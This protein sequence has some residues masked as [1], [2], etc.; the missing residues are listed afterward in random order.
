[1]LAKQVVKKVRSKPKGSVVLSCFP[2]SSAF[3]TRFQAETRTNIWF[4]GDFHEEK[5]LLFLSY[6]FRVAGLIPKEIYGFLAVGKNLY[7][8][9]TFSQETHLRGCLFSK[10]NFIDLLKQPK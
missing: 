2:P 4:F 5:N 1:M 3:E 7:L 6:L 10:E 9:L 8:K